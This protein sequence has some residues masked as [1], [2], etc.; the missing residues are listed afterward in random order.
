MERRLSLIIPILKWI[1]ISPDLYGE[2]NPFYGKTHSEESKRINSEKT[3]QWHKENPHI[4]EKQS[5]MCRKIFTGRKQS[6]EHKKRIGEKSKGQA[7]I[8]NIQTNECIKVKCEDLHLYDKDVWKNPSAIKQM[9]RPLK[10]CPHCGFVG[11]ENTSFYRWHSDN[12]R[13]RTA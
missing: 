12:C 11:R 3:K 5:E 4:A 10:T 13:K 2:K 6:E 7:I 1:D 8:K 9:E